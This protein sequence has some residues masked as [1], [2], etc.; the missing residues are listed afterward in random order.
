MGKVYT[1]MMKGVFQWSDDWSL[2]KPLHLESTSY[3][4]TDGIELIPYEET[5]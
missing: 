2:A 1:G 5:Q 3:L 4:L